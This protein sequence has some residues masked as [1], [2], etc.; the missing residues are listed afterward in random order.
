M[1]YEKTASRPESGDKRREC[2][3]CGTCCRKEGPAFHR[4]DKD[5]IESG[6]IRLKDIFTIRKGELA[7]DNVRGELLPVSSDIL[8]IKGREGS[9]T[10]MFFMEEENACAIYQSRPLECRV[11]KCWDTRDIR[12]LY[13]ADRLTR[14]DLLADIKGPWEIIED[15]EERCSHDEIRRLTESARAGK[16]EE[17]ME[18]LLHIIRYDFHIRDLMTSKAGMDPG[19]MDFLL[20]RPLTGITHALGVKLNSE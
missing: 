15:H 11:L 10:C 13:D 17:D 14:E 1:V 2:A 5:L 18:A 4:R 9:W 12:K 6:A 7:R 8:K 19:I 3:R 20:G 16:N